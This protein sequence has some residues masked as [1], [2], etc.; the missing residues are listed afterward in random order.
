MDHVPVVDETKLINKLALRLMPLLCLLYL[1]AYIDRAN[2]SFTKLQMLDSLGL[3][4]AVYG[5]GA[6][7]FFIGYMLFEVPSNI[8]LHRYGAPK[9]LARIVLSWGVVTLFLAFAHTATIFYV[10]RFLLGVAEAGLYPGVIFYLT[11]WF[12]AQHRLR[13]LGYFTIGS[14]MG[15]MIGAPICG[16][17]LDQ[18]GLLNLQGWQ[19]V[20]IFTGIP[21]ILLAAVVFFGLPRSPETAKFLSADERTWLTASLAREQEAITSQRHPGHALSVLKDPRVLGLACLYMMASISIYGVGY[22]LP[23]V[24]RGFGVTNTVNGLLNI[25]PW[26]A[27]TIVL[28]VLPSKLRT[29]RKPMQAMC[30]A[31]SLGVLFFLGSVFLPDNTWRFMAL[32]LGAPCM[33]LLLPCF[34]TL[35]TRFLTGVQAAAGIATINSLSNLGGFIAQNLFPYVKGATGSVQAPMLIPSLCMTIFAIVSL[36][37]LFRIQPP[38]AA[39]VPAKASN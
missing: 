38:S 33:Y 23:T 12:P 25:L 16:Y 30:C 19:L 7:L 24:V 9:W 22:W 10:L 6:S 3:S 36:I 4:E 37:L 20:F 5:L 11:L 18:A 27:A 8:L 28:L 17:L 29:G 15:N 34:W 2:I 13:M 39:P 21:P 31:A 1:V 14:S 32:T 26:L 35:P